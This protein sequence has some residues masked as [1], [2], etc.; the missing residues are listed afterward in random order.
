MQW[1]M[2]AIV[3][4]VLIGCVGNQVRPVLGP[5]VDE[6]VGWSEYCQRHPEDPSC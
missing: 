2:A 4:M 1:A 5:V 3:G 6:P